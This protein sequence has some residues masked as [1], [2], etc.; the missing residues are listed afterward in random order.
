MEVLKFQE[1]EID[2]KL[3]NGHKK[4]WHLFHVITKAK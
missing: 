4:H 1:E 2:R 3:S